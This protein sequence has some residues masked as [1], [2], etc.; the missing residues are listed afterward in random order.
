MPRAHVKPVPL[1]ALSLNQA[2]TATGLRFERL[3]AAARRGELHVVKIGTKSR[4]SISELT[5]W[6][7]AHPPATREVC[8]AG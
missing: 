5:R 4:V 7:D 2:S 8:H 3:A 1:V 6:V